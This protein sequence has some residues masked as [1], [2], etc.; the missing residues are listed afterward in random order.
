M[1]MLIATYILF[2]VAIFM[3]INSNNEALLMLSQHQE[4]VKPQAKKI[5]TLPPGAVKISECVP[6]MGDHWVRPQDIPGGPYYV[7]YQGK[8]VSVEYMFKPE[9]I[10]GQKVANYT[11]PEFEK[12]MTENNYTL[13]DVVRNNEKVYDLGGYNYDSIHVAWTAPHAGYPV[14]HMDVHA[15]VIPEAEVHAICPDA[16]IED[17]HSPEVIKTIQ[18]YNIPVPEAPKP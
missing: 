6:D 11:F 17:V 8:V 4:P 5:V 7:V 9:D 2:G 15:Y 12:Y 10:P 18:E 1:F 14:P 13:L 3:L 16:G